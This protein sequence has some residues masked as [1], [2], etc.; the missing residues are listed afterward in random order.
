MEVAMT[1][2]VLS[3]HGDHALGF[4]GLFLMLAVGRLAD[5]A[6]AATH[7]AVERLRAFVARRAIDGIALIGWLADRLPR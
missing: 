2:T 7:T 6:Y 5:P 1:N 4:L 3:F